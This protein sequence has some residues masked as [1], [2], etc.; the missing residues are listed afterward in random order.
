MELQFQF[1]VLRFPWVRKFC[2]LRIFYSNSDSFDE[3]SQANWPNC[4][5]DYSKT[6]SNHTWEKTLKKGQNSNFRQPLDL[7]REN[8]QLTD[9]KMIIMVFTPRDIIMRHMSDKNWKI[10][11]LKTFY[12]R[13]NVIVCWNIH[14]KI[15]IFIRE[16]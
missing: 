16:N 3:S 5:V 9:F 6:W 1:C 15:I 12:I 4:S 11:L 10:F 2:F 13:Q 8:D 14:H 7:N